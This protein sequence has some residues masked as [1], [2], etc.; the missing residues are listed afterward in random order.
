MN[1]REDRKDG[2]MRVMIV[3]ASADPGKFG[4]RAVRAYLRQEAEVLP[5]NP[6]GGEI[7][8]VRVYGGVDEPEGPI[9]RVLMYVPP[10]VGLGVI[11][12]L[13]E[14][15]RLRGDVGELWLNPGSESRALIERARELG[16]EP[17]QACAIIDIGERP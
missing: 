15:Q 9:D 10:R 12:A 3:G 16:F 4:N 1:G 13:G 14:R 7:E 2:D 17:I 11:E 5:V 6:G 8:G